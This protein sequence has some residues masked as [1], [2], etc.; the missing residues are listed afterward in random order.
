[1]YHVS[2]FTFSI[3]SM[4]DTLKWFLVLEIL[5][6]IGLPIAHRLFAA[7]PSRGYAFAKPLALLL[8]G[9]FFW[10]LGSFKF[11]MN[12]TS[13]VVFVLLI[14]TGVSAYFAWRDREALKVFWREN[15]ALIIATELVCLAFY[16]FWII[17]RA[18]NP[19]ITSTEKP[20]DFL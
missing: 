6:L 7:L 5:G 3:E 20:M 14:I 18:Y 15:R 2:R 19:D 11:L 17:Y 12:T 16:V 8:V 13:A 9:Y 1:M 4:I 10:L